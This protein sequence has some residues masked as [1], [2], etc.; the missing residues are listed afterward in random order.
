MPGMVA[1]SE[2]WQAYSGLENLEKFYSKFDIKHSVEF[3]RT[4][5]FFIR[6][7]EI[8]TSIKDGW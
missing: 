8:R 7:Y 1:L 2:M 6:F 4:G 3:S 5:H